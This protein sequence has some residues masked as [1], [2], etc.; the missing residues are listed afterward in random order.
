MLIDDIEI[1]KNLIFPCISNGDCKM[2][3]FLM[4]IFLCEVS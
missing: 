2:L 3:L 1:Y 4:S